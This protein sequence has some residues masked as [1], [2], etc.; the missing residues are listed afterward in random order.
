MKNFLISSTV[1]IIYCLMCS[2]STVGLYTKNQA[3]NKFCKTDS[4]IFE[5]VIHDTIE[6]PGAKADTIF[7]IS[8]C[9]SLGTDSVTVQHGKISATYVRNGNKIKLSA[10][11]KGDSIPFQKP[12]KITVPCNCPPCTEPVKPSFWDNVVLWVK[13]AL[14]LIGIVVLLVFGVRLLINKLS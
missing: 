3:I 13:N 5:T 7:T 2:C 1:A 11:Y 4:V 12:I 6:V 14:S 8:P 9:N 10:N